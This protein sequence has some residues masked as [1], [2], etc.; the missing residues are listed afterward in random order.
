MA[1]SGVNDIQAEKKFKRDKAKRESITVAPAEQ[2][3]KKGAKRGH[4]KDDN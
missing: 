2:T 1:L 4:V 3:E